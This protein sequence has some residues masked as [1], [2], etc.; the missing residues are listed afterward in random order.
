MNET[1]K[2]DKDGRVDEAWLD[3]VLTDNARRARCGEQLSP[4]FGACCIRFV[5]SVI[6]NPDYGYV[7]LDRLTKAEVC[8][9]VYLHLCRN[10]ARYNPSKRR[11]ASAWIITVA[12]NAISNCVRDV[13]QSNAVSEIV[14][15]V[16]G[17]EALSRLDGIDRNA[18]QG[19][20]LSERIAALADFRL[21][22]NAK[23]RIL[24]H[25]MRNCGPKRDGRSLVERAR[26]HRSM[27]AA[28]MADQA[29]L[30][31]RQ[32]GELLKLIEERKNGR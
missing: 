9:R 14:S 17:A 21:D 23:E 15:M 2:T 31:R 8:S 29:R 10:V 3:V 1:L 20:L 32:G 26:V 24:G 18:P 19:R 11:K 4:E 28:R 27:Q 22:A 7:R 5:D 13:I 25:A 30:D 6:C 16:V 12:K